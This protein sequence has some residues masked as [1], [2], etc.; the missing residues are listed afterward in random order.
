MSR[1]GEDLSKKSFSAPAVKD[2]VIYAF[3]LLRM[4]K[5]CVIPQHLSDLCLNSLVPHLDD[6]Q[7]VGLTVGMTLADQIATIESKL[8]ILLK[9]LVVLFATVP[10]SYFTACQR[11]S[12]RCDHQNAEIR[13]FSNCLERMPL[14]CS[15]QRTL[16]FHLNFRQIRLCPQASTDD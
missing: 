7:A 8:A 6:M 12:G 1:E 4:T 13:R 14:R 3:D 5:D 2:G 16:S 9:N 15:G 10:Q 11:I